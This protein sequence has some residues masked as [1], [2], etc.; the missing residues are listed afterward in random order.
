M[1]TQSISQRDLETRARMA[2]RKRQF[3]VLLSLSIL[4]LTACTRDD[5]YLPALLA[6]PMASYEADGIVLIDAW[7]ESEGRDIIMDAPTHAEVGRRYRIEDQNQ[8]EDVLTEAVAF[9][10]SQGWRIQAES[11]LEYRGTMETSAG[12]GRLHLSLPAEDVVQDP[13]GPR[14]L[15]ILLDFGPVRFDET[16]TSSP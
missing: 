2:T 10:R 5:T 8:A 4:A 13:D 16:T 11:S 7:E 9:A 14:L 1:G 15:R 12:T 6:D 3:V